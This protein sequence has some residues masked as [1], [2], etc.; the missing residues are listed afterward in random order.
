MMVPTV[1]LYEVSIW[2]VERVQK[3]AE[4]RAAEAEREQP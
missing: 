3:Q 1:L 2:L 4:A